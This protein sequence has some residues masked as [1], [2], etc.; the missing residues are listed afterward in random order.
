MKNW[1][2]WGSFTLYRVCRSKPTSRPQSGPPCPISPNLLP[3]K[4]P[5]PSG[6]SERVRRLSE[7]FHWLMRPYVETCIEAFGTQRYMFESNFPPD[8]E[9]FSYFG[10][11]R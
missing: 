10:E 8:K 5:A 3:T 9:G 1:K 4:F 7:F 2:R 11:K 6:K